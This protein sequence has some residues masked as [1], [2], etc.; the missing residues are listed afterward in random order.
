M[1]RVKYGRRIAVQWC[2]CSAHDA[3]GAN[4]T[5]GIIFT[6]DTIVAIGTIVTI[7]VFVKVAT[8]V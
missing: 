8:I 3:T 4:V 6:I 1:T 7:G 2:H 5:N